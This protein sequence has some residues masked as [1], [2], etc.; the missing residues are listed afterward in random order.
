MTSPREHAMGVLYLALTALCWGFVASTVKRLTAD[1]DSYTISFF[2]VALATLVFAI[3]A[4][5][6]GWRHVRWFLP[7]IVIGALGR[8]GNYL[9]YNAGLTWM[10]SNAATILAPVQAIATV[11]LARWF[12]GERA[13][14]KGLGLLVSVAGL[15]LIWWRGRGW[16]TLRDPRYLG[17]NA[18]LVLAGLASA[19]QFTSQKAL[20]SRLSGPQILLPV[21]ALSTLLTAPF[22]AAAGGFAHTY[23]GVTWLLLL[24]LGFVLTGGSFFLLGE[25]YKRCDASTAVVI[26]NTSSFFTLLWSATLL[27][28]EVGVIMIVGATLSVGGAVLVVNADRRRHELVREEAAA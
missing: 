6:A 7:W 5:R 23:S 13:R 27:G 4:R 21:F 22:A 19:L 17:G 9:A 14:G 1:V 8:A 20:S 18:L 16:E 15:L 11:L 2:R 28:E 26:T 12:L 3:L 24:F 10:P 25:G